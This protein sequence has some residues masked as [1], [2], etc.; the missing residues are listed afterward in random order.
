VAPAYVY[1]CPGC[2]SSFLLLCVPSTPC[3]S[4]PRARVQWFGQ[5]QFPGHILNQ[6]TGYKSAEPNRIEGMNGDV[7]GSASWASFPL[8]TASTEHK[9]IRNRGL[10]ARTTHFFYP[11][12]RI[13]QPSSILLC[14]FFLLVFYLGTFHV[15][16]VPFS[17]FSTDISRQGEYLDSH[18]GGNIVT[19]V[20]EYSERSLARLPGQQ[21]ESESESIKRGDLTAT[22]TITAYRTNRVPNQ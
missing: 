7:I 8:T 16:R 11:T 17:I 5:S 2:S 20:S 4:G 15:Y 10:Y 9:I 19:V 6:L 13:P 18:S 12:Q 21:K 14:L 3:R 1:T 22:D